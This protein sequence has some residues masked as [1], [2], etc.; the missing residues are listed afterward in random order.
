[1]TDRNNINLDDEEQELLES[2]EK[3][4]WR[5]VSD[6]KKEALFAKEAAASYLRKDASVL[7]EYAAGHFEDKL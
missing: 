5:T 7:H 1:M 3:G 2:V 4:E 6:F